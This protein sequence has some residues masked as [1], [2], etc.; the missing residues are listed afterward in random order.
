MALKLAVFVFASL[1]VITT[2]VSSD[3]K[4]AFMEA[5][6]AK[7][8][9]V[10]PVPAPPAARIIKDTKECGDACKERCKLHS[11]QNVCSRACITCCSVCKC[12]PPGTYGHTELCGKCYT[13]WKTH[14]NRTKC[15]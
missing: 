11:R 8:P 9:V 15:P 6:Y 3:A 14:G 7:A 12:V 2:R 10:A 5:G 1:L 13:D 4:D